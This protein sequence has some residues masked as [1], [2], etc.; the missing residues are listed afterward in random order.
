VT[1]VVEP[2]ALEISDLGVTFAQ[3][4]VR[5]VDGVSLFVR[6]GER[7][8]IVGESGSGKSTTALSVLRL[9]D[10]T[11]VDYDAGSGIEVAGRNV[12]AMNPRQLREMRGAVAGMVFQDPL[13]SLNPLFRIG[14]Q[15]RDVI[16]AH[17]DISRAQARDRA[18][19]ALGDAGMPDPEQM[20][21]RLPSELSGG[22]RQRVVI[23][24]AIS[25]GPSLLIA[26]EPTS[27][28][29]ATVQ[30]EVLQTFRRLSDTRSMGLLLISHDIGVIY[31]MCDRVY[32]MYQGHVVEEGS[33][34]QVIG[35]PQ[36]AYTKSLIDSAMYREAGRSA[37]HFV[38]P[39]ALP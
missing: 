9:H 23:A 31:R 8:G 19:S 32:V 15:V 27:A 6:R 37:T 25:C 30:A 10:E 36:H 34:D 22:L 24:M 28:L 17:F 29:D 5:A 35:N 3:Q 1:D 39:E 12:M 33:T 20:Y 21:G 4:S 38:E 16:S 18:I 26:D 11:S 13:S 2:N 14:N 7:V